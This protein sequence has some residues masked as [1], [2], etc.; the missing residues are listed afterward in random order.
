MYDFQGF[1]SANCLGIIYGVG[2]GVE[3]EALTLGDSGCVLFGLPF[4][5]VGVWKGNCCWFLCYDETNTTCLLALS[6]WI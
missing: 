2:N 6:L 4:R 3:G 5:V 1:I